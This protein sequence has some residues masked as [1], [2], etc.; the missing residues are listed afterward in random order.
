MTVIKTRIWKE[1]IKLLR[2]KFV[3]MTQKISR[4]NQTNKLFCCTAG[5]DPFHWSSKDHRTKIIPLLFN[6]DITK[7]FTEWIPFKYLIV[8]IWSSLLHGYDEIL[9]VASWVHFSC[10]GQPSVG[11]LLLSFFFDNSAQRVLS[12]VIIQ[13]SVVSKNQHWV[14]AVLYSNILSRGSFRRSPMT[15]TSFSAM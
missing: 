7:L 11:S 2:W 8:H 4:I 10:L 14:H 5:Q 6:T 13:P 3:G 12:E 1:L 9:A 15:Y